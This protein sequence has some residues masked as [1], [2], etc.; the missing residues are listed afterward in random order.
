MSRRARKLPKAIGVPLSST[1]CCASRWSTGLGRSPW[2]QLIARTASSTARLACRRSAFQVP[3][4]NKLDCPACTWCRPLLPRCTQRAPLV[5]IDAELAPSWSRRFTHEPQ[6]SFT[7]GRQAQ[8][9]LTPTASRSFKV[10]WWFISHSDLTRRT[11]HHLLS[12]M[13]S[14]SPS[15]P[16]GPRHGLFDHRCRLLRRSQSLGGSDPFCF[17]STI[18]H[19]F[20]HLFASESTRERH[21]LHDAVWISATVVQGHHLFIVSESLIVLIAIGCPYHPSVCGY[22]PSENRSCHQSGSS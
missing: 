12:S 11:L 7:F 5:D 14:P 3:S 16:T 20:P 18:S 10:R 2:S 8:S 17:G 22:W 15:K 4:A 1:R 6:L 19:A 13:P 9:S 21:D